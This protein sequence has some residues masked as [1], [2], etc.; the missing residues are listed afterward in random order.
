MATTLNP[1][2]D[3]GIAGYLESDR[4]FVLNNLEA[5]VAFLEKDHAL[6]AKMKQRLTAVV[7]YDVELNRLELPPNGDDYNAIRGFLLGQPFELP[8][9]EGR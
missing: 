1:R 5:C 4:D 6:L 8:K 7:A 2:R 3:H 9:V